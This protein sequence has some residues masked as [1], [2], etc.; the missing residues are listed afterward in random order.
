MIRMIRLKEVSNFRFLPLTEMSIGGISYAS[1]GKLI[2]QALTGVINNRR[3]LQK[4]NF[5]FSKYHIPSLLFHRQ[6]LLWQFMQE[7]LWW[8]LSVL[9]VLQRS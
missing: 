4:I 3:N 7:S 1:N 8:L 5:C 6:L 9:H 2:G